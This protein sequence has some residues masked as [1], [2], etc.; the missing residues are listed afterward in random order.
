MAHVFLAADLEPTVVGQQ[1]LVFT[2]AELPL[3]T[4]DRDETAVA[5]TTER[6]DLPYLLGLRAH[7]LFLL[8]A[9]E[10]LR[11]GVVDIG[12]DDFIVLLQ[13]VQGQF[14]L[15]WRSLDKFPDVVLG[16]VVGVEG[17][18][19]DLVQ[20]F[21]FGYFD[22]VRMQIVLGFE[23]AEDNGFLLAMCLSGGAEFVQR[24]V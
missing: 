11:E 7:D 24:F 20:Q 18:A 14:L 5:T 21:A 22:L 13:L 12:V 1:T 10:T 9:E 8:V 6:T 17:A 16:D 4:T 2:H 23:V 19:G 15:I 3:L